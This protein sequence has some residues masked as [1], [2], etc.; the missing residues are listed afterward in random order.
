MT[1]LYQ[2][3][4][5]YLQAE[6]HLSALDLDEQTIKDTLEGL[7]GEIE[8]KSTNIA[9]FI[10]NLETTAQAIKEAEAEM[11]K[12]RKAIETRINSLESY[13]LE[14]MVRTGI[15]RI[16]CP[17]FRISIRDNPP[18][19]DV[20]NENEIPQEFMRIPEPPPPVPDKKKIM[21]A[22]KSG[23]EVP[24]CVLKKTKRL[25]IK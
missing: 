20:F 12:R 15:T 22:I 24:G 18:S 4:A 8:I 21:E 11:S 19:V 2:L 14:N 10:R 7:S 3:T 5:E 25:E 16:D 1:S 13:T 6:E 17:Y 9:M 23:V